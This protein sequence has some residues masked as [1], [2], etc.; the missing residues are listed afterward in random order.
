MIENSFH[1]TFKALK[2]EI[3]SRKICDIRGL[4][5]FELLKYLC[6]YRFLLQVMIENPQLDLLRLST[7]LYDVSVSSNRFSN[8]EMSQFGASGTEGLRKNKR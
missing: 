2:R 6:F 7:T 5:F 3:K 1:F 4:Y 8:P